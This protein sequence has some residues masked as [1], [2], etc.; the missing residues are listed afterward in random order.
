[1]YLDFFPKPEKTA[2][3]ETYALYTLYIHL[4]NLTGKKNKLKNPSYFVS[5]LPPGGGCTIRKI[6]GQILPMDSVTQVFIMQ[7]ARF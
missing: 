2:Q 7:K 1:M 4:H 6:K 3:T 5:L